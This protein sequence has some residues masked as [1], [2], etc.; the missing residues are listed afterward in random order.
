MELVL[1]ELDVA[2]AALCPADADQDGVHQEPTIKTANN[3][4]GYLETGTQS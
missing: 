1:E 2:A 4:T 3:E